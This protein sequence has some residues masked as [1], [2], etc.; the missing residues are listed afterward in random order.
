M[1]NINGSGGSA[2]PQNMQQHHLHLQAKLNG[3][4]PLSST[5]VTESSSGT[6]NVLGLQASSAGGTPLPHMNGKLV[7]NS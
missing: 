6:N 1:Q 7:N 5:N 4:A 2:G 3:G